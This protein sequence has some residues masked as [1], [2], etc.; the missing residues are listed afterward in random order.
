M[1]VDAWEMTGDELR[2]GWLWEDD[3]NSVLAARNEN[4]WES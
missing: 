3:D 2:T 4:N 1:K